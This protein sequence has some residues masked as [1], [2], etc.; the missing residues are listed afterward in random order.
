MPIGSSGGQEPGNISRWATWGVS[1]LNWPLGVSGWR[2]AG[3]CAIFPAADPAERL[4]IA[5]FDDL[6]IALNAQSRPGGYYD[7]NQVWL[8]LESA[9]PRAVF[10]QAVTDLA[11]VESSVYAWDRYND[12]RRE[13]ALKAVTGIL[14]AAFWFAW[15]LVT[16]THLVITASRRDSTGRTLDILG[17]DRH[18]LRRL[19]AAEQIILLVPTLIFG[20][21]ASVLLVYLLLPFLSL[22]ESDTLYLSRAS[23][24]AMLLLAL[25]LIVPVMVTV[26]VQQHEQDGQL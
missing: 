4:V 15:G 11:G 8:A 25:T 7:A 6:R 14:F 3:A 22:I 12:L 10:R 13:P 23:L 19:W 16:L 20:A 5:P 26:A 18:H 17:L 9:E 24:G 21:L 1:S 2:I